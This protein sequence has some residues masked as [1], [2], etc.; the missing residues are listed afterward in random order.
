MSALE[1]VN[2]LLKSGKGFYKI[3]DK[4]Q[5]ISTKNGYCKAEVKIDQEHTNPMGGLHGGFSATLIDAISIASLRTIVDDNMMHLSKEM[6]L[7]YTKAARVG[8]EII[9][10]G[11]TIKRGDEIFH[12]E[13]E[14]KNKKTGD[15][16]VRGTQIVYLK[17]KNL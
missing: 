13:A 5:V 17:P 1:K 12:L 8:D 9:I 11:K 2:R 14:V 6:N 4:V 7:I 3:L 16:L 10:E 15:L